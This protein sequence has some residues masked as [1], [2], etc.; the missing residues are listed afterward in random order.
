MIYQASF[1]DHRMGGVTVSAKAIDVLK[2]RLKGE[3]GWQGCGMGK[4]EWREI[5][6]VWGG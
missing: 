3:L 6:E 1:E 4:G 2:P 5:W